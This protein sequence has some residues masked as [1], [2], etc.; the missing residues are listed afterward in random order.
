MFV[1]MEKKRKENSVQISE[2]VVYVH[3]RIITL[4]GLKSNAT[5]SPGEYVFNKEYHNV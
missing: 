2:A 1:N 5:R 3:L 4:K